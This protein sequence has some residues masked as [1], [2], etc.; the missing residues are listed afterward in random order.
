MN[1][2]REVKALIRHKL[3]DSDAVQNLVE[4]NIFTAH[5]K[6]PD[7]GYVSYP[8]I[9]V[10]TA[11]GFSRYQAGLQHLNLDISA[12]S[13]IS[14]DEAEEVYQKLF[15]AL[16]A[17]RLAKENIAAKGCARELARPDTFFDERTKSW[18]VRGRWLAMT[19][20]G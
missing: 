8:C 9:S 4:N 3:L 12:H 7:R 14:S 20:Q 2:I 10:A 19:A 16:H 1:N 11:G 5:P 13:K 18:G 17:A 15:E 6:D